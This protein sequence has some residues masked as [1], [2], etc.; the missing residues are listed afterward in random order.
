[1]ACKLFFT[2]EKACHSIHVHVLLVDLRLCASDYLGANAINESAGC[3]ASRYLEITARNILHPVDLHSANHR[4]P[5]R[6]HCAT[7]LEQNWTH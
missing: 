2:K 7:E 4:S 5:S 6:A 3:H 1:L